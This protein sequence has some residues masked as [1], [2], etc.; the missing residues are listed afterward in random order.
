MVVGCGCPGIPSTA[1]RPHLFSS[2]STRPAASPLPPPRPD[3][4]LGFALHHRGTNR[5]WRRGAS[6]PASPSS[7]PASRPPNPRPSLRSRFPSLPPLCLRMPFRS[8]SGSPLV[9]LA[10]LG[11]PCV[12]DVLGWPPRGILICRLVESVSV[13][14]P[15]WLILGV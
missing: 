4:L 14:F 2:R 1:H 11:S 8:D 3:L 12:P 13:R 9:P 10:D 15:F 5:K 7:K 6:D